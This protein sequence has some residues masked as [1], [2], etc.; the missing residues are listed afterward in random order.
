MAVPNGVVG[1]D[2][3]RGWNDCRADS[4]T[5]PKTDDVRFA[6]AMLDYIAP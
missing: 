6:L 1:P 5:N 4:T 3:M 2:D